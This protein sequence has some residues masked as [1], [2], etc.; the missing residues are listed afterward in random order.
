VLELPP[1]GGAPY[2]PGVP[3]LGD[4][5]AAPGVNVLGVTVLG[6]G[7]AARGVDVLG[8]TVLGDGVRLPRSGG[9]V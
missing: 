1:A 9:R 8:V 2:V 5:A 3:A 6:D 7:A 4:G